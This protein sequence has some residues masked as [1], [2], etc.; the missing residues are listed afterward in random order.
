MPS[1]GNASIA[2][3]EVLAL[4][5]TLVCCVQLEAESH[6]LLKRAI[7]A[8]VDAMIDAELPMASGE[9]LRA[10]ATVLGRVFACLVSVWLGY[11]IGNR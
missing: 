11:A 9:R 7:G 8:R 5:P 4:F 10:G 6:E 2:S 1:P 3:N